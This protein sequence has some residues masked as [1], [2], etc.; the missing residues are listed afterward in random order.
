MSRIA[1]R[2]AE[3]KAAGEAAFIP[4]LTCGDPSLAR[5]AELV[6]ALDRAGADVI[7]LGVPFSDPLADGPTI[8]AASTRALAAGTTLA[9]ILGLVREL[10]PEVRAAL[11]LFTYANP[12]WRFGLERF[13]REAAAAGADGLLVPDLPPEEAAALL[14]PARAHDLDT[15][16]LAAPTSTP[17]RLALIAAASRGF[18]YAV[19][20]TGVTGAR[21]ELPPDLAAFVR[22]VK[23]AANP[24]P[25]A[26]GFGISTP[27]QA[28]TVARLADGVVVG[29]ALVKIVEETGDSPALVAR[30]ERAA[31]KL[32]AEI[33]R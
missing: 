5:T 14:K 12:V 18:V 16:F 20:L 28:R 10:R 31:R 19:S 17:E 2:F 27:A 30:V 4:Y 9:K 25:V 7:E 13:C 23:R 24:L 1:E 6:R 32:A 22:R 11:L 8:Q 29:S 15:V 3:R 33:H 21:R 26:V